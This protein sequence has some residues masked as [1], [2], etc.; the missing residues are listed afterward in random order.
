M[1][2]SKLL[3]RLRQQGRP[4]PEIP[5]AKPTTDWHQKF[6][7]ICDLSVTSRKTPVAAYGRDLK[8]LLLW[9]GSRAL[10]KLKLNDLSDFIASLQRIN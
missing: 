5:V 10:T 4:A 1:P 8:K 2:P 3:Q 9:L 6:T 7:I